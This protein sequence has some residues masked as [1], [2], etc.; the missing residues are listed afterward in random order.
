MGAHLER[1]EQVRHRVQM[2]LGIFG[3]RG[4]LPLHLK[5][6]HSVGDLLTQHLEDLED[7]AELKG[8]VVC[9]LSDHFSKTYKVT[10]P[11]GLFTR[12]VTAA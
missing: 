11:V 1:A 2:L 9:V 7:E 4:V 8:G 3:A 12:A 6:A 10:A 5:P